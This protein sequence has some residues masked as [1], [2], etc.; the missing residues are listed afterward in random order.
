MVRQR[1]FLRGYGHLFILHLILRQHLA[2]HPFQNRAFNWFW[3]KF[4]KAFVAEH[5][6]CAADG[7]GGKR[8]YGKVF[9]F[10]VLNGPDLSH[11]FHAVKA[12]HHMVQ[13]NNIVVRGGTPLHRFLS[14]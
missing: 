1:S 7:V 9:I 6:P 5:F 14:A 8:D 3:Y 2:Q 13:E 11:G 4:R 12:R 10:P